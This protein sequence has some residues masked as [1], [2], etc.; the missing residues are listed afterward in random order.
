MPQLTFDPIDNLRVLHTKYPDAKIILFYGKGWGI[1]GAKKYLETI[2]GRVE[3]LDYYDKLSPQRIIDVLNTSSKLNRIST[4]NLIS[5]KA[6]TLLALKDIVRKSKIEDIYVIT[7]KEFKNNMSNC[8]EKIASYFH[9][10]K[11]VVRSSSKKEDAYEESNA[12][13]FT[14]VNNV[15]S[16]DLENIK[17]AIHT[18]IMSY[19]NDVDDDEQILIQRKTQNVIMSGVIFT[20]DIQRN[21]PYYVINYDD[22]GSTESVTSGMC[23]TIAW[24]AHTVNRKLVP[25]KW[26]A[27][28][29][30]VWELEDILS[31]ILL[32]IEFAVTDH[33]VV[34][35]QVRPLAAA[36]KYGRIKNNKKIE[37]YRKDA[38]FKYNNKAK[39]G[40][41]C[42][43]DMAFWNPAE[44]IG[45]N[46]HNL[47]FSLYR[48]VI[49]KSAWNEGLVTMGYQIVPGELMV[50][51]GNKPYI[52]VE[53]SFEAL[54]PSE[55]SEELTTK[56][57]NY[58]I[59]TLKKDLSAHDKI[60]FEISHNC[61]D[62]SLHNRLGILKEGGFSSREIEKLE[63]SL[64]RL[65]IKV[66]NSYRQTLIEDTK[67]LKQLEGIR[68]DIL[69]ITKDTDNISII[70]KSIRTL[71]DAIEKYGA[72]QFSRQARCAFIAKSLCKSL[73]NE[74]YITSVQLDEFMSS[75]RTIAVDYDNDYHAVIN[76][77]MSKDRFI[78]IYGH[79]RAGTYNIR[80]PR[81]D[82]ME[83]LFSNIGE[84]FDNIERKER[85]NSGENETRDHLDNLFFTMNE[86]V[87]KALIDSNIISLSADEVISF[88][89]EATE[90]R[91]YFKF[92]FTKSLS[93]AIELIRR[94][95][96]IAGINADSL[97]YLEIPEVFSAEYY[98]DGN[99]LKEFWTL[100]IDSRREIYNTN[101]E[102][103]LPEIICSEQDF[104]YIENIK[105]RPNY[106]S[107]NCV[108]GDVVVL[109]DD[110]NVSIEG[111]IVVIEQAD[112]GYDWI[113]TKGILGLITKYGG[114]ASHMAIRCAEFNIPAAIGCG[115]SLFRYSIE[116]ARIT[117]DCKNE[118]LIR[119]EG[120]NVNNNI[121][122][123]S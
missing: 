109:S 6:N 67:D 57:C 48:E 7:V 89:K 54:I 77:D 4:S 2:G 56:L 68:L 58:Y 10:D 100:M 87:Q 91:E 43:S 41:T 83:H 31:D 117:I 110:D 33:S 113:F 18:V 97:S 111:K 25:Q 96:A 61:F 46:P 13:H 24:L 92:I 30:A 76:G 12:G 72:P 15:N 65:T 85:K 35:F 73:C 93:Y 42:F 108:E 82:Q 34:I 80:S 29:D 39:N 11:I 1:L 115:A 62:F 19:G 74:N 40:L 55:V 81:Y 86:A 16:V 26:K 118:K 53:R 3:K 49:T 98:S 17:D 71:L 63:N 84:T 121:Y 52:N 60:E 116:S 64:R 88:I 38:V 37:N 44:I 21:R 120:K 103:I 50:R 79:L 14:S 112:P 66:I 114:A 27:L 75:I 102:L 36:Y 69:N 5:T 20:R 90:Q 122:S 23:G 22:S 59:D 8:L 78:Q 45:N 107:D 123:E 32:D 99:Q 9:N 94:I 119:M 70:A 106:I 47:D 28:M 105:T 51:F 104:D 101:S 95:G